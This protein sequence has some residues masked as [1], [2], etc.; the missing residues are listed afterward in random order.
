M[1]VGACERMCTCDAK[2]ISKITMYNSYKIDTNVHSRSL[3]VGTG[4]VIGSRW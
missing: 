4:A 2:Y 3:H 1:C